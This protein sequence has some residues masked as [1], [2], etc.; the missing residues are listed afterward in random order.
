[1]AS[2]AQLNQ[3]AA[4]LAEGMYAIMGKD[5]ESVYFFQIKKV[6][7]SHRIFRLE[8]SPGDYKRHTMKVT[9]Q[10]AAL[11]KIS[12]NPIAALKL[13]GQRAKWCGVC[14]SALTNQVSLEFGI[15][16]VCRGK[17]GV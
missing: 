9:W 12:V 15:G 3:M 10:A 8:G 4:N 17:L 13:Y 7:N 5:G 6:K 2:F 11:T 16:P 14:N 1:M